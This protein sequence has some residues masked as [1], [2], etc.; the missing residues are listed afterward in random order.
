MTITMGT[1]MDMAVTPTEQ[2]VTS[3]L[4]RVAGVLPA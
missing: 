2:W 4:E 3:S 1:R